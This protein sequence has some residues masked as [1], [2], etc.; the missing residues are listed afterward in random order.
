[1][2]VSSYTLSTTAFFPAH[3]AFDKDI[4]EEEAV[5]DEK[6]VEGL[7]W[8]LAGDGEAV[9]CIIDSSRISGRYQVCRHMK[10]RPPT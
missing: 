2:C 3:D 8:S 4:E 7:Q 6:D 1:M 9:A 10:T 5:D